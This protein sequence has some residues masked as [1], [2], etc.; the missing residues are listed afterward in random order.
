MQSQKTKD[1][2]SDG[3][4][5]KMEHDSTTARSLMSAVCGLRSGVLF[6]VV[7]AREWCVVTRRRVN[8]TSE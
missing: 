7:L 3:W 6:V 5:N 4:L 8:A 1:H 2:R